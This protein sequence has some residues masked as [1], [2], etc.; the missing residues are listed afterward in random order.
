[1]ASV[2]QP[3]APGGE[4][5]ARA[6]G[7]CLWGV[8]LAPGAAGSGGDMWAV[9]LGRGASKLQ[10]R[11]VVATSLDVWETCGHHPRI[12][13]G[14]VDEAASRGPLAE[15]TCRVSSRKWRFY[16]DN[17]DGQMRSRSS[18]LLGRVKWFLFLF[19]FI[20]QMLPRNKSSSEPRY[21][22]ECGGV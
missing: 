2:P 11:Q 4:L 9:C 8:L 22:Q 21:F 7:P 13:G 14:R 15:V 12:T 5:R 20:P 1:M 19:N 16:D 17:K 10:G 6:S 18:S 3:T